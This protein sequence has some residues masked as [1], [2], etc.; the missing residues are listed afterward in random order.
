MLHHAGHHPAERL[1]LL[2]ASGAMIVSSMAVVATQ[3][4]IEP[5]RA[6]RHSEGR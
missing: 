6:Q 5:F 2:V 3:S 1:T 4:D